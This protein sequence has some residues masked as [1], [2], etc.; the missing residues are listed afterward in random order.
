MHSG[1]VGL[2]QAGQREKKEDKKMIDSISPFHFDALTSHTI[3]RPEQST[4]TTRKTEYKT[5]PET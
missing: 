3:C 1:G 4:L 5:I 2:D